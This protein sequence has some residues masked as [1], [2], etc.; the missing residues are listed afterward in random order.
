MLKLLIDSV[1]EHKINN[2]YNHGMAFK[3]SISFKWKFQLDRP[4]IFHTVVSTS[5]ELV[6][7]TSFHKSA[8]YLY[9]SNMSVLYQLQDQCTNFFPVWKCQR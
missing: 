7:A 4:L 8:F 1:T 3:N 6:C 5:L 9:H 2:L